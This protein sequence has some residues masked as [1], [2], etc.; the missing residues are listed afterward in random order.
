MLSTVICSITGL[1]LECVGSTVD[2]FKHH[3]R[4]SRETPSVEPPT[5]GP[6]FWENI[7]LQLLKKTSFCVEGYERTSLPEWATDP[8]QFCP[9]TFKFVSTG[10]NILLLS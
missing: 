3:G 1:C 7:I 9:V 8:L 6:I 5:P 4:R 2:S 10:L